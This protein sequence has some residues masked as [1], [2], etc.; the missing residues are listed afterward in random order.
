M[1][2]SSTA[3]TS[4]AS[5]FAFNN[6]AESIYTVIPPRF[7]GAT[8]NAPAPQLVAF[9]SGLAHV[10]LPV[11]TSA[12]SSQNEAWILGGADGLIIAVDIRG[13]GHITT[14]PSDQTTVSLQIPFGSE[15]AIPAY[16]VLSQGP[17][18]FAQTGSQLVDGGSN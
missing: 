10:T 5:T 17:C 9:F 15:E 2:V 13:T 11:P 1:S 8:H 14:Y 3:G 6:T 4:G 12:N 16:R 18:H 7:N